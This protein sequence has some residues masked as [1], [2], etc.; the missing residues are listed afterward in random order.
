MWGCVDAFLKLDRCVLMKNYKNRRAP[1]QTGRMY[2]LAMVA[3]LVVVM[4]VQLVTLHNK[5]K[6]YAARE[7]QLSRELEEQEDRKKELSDYEQYTKT[8]EYTKNMAKS[9]LGLVS[10][11]EIIFR[12]R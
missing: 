8:E 6:E 12:E 4:L 9:K 7:V 2:L 3:F 11:N 1:K 10:P 5:S